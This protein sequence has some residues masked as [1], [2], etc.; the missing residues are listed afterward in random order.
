MRQLTVETIDLLFE[1]DILN[2]APLL[3][4]TSVRFMDPYALLILQ[5]L[6]SERGECGT[7]L[8]IRWPRDLRVAR[9]IHAMGVEMPGREDAPSMPRDPESALQPTTSIEDESGIGRVVDGFHHRLSERYP[10]TPSSRRA[11]VAVMIELFQNIPH[12]SNATGGVEDPHG[13]AAMQD[14]E[15]SIFLAVADKGVGLAASLG[16]RDGYGGLSDAGAL[17]VILHQG[18]SRFDDPGRGGELRRIAELVRSWDGMFALRTGRALY[19]CDALGG[20]TYDVPG[21]PGV[22][23][24]L[25]LPRRA[26]V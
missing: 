15:D 12:H 23:L 1:R 5:L 7:P 26:L 18:L 20:D 3:D 14:Y 2:E 8:E 6:V 17:D 24:A 9:W 22:Q 16:L 4:L 11:L 21:F 25:R 10:L 13:L 19:H